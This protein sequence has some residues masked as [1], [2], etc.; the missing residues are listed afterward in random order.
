MSQGQALKLQ[1]HPTIPTAL[2]FLF[3]GQDASPQLFLSPGLYFTV[4]NSSPTKLKTQVNAFFY[5]LPWSCCFNH[6]SSTV[7]R[8]D[9]TLG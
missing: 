7:T 5:K 4:M 6:S 2:C 8:I 3:V 1:K 9:G